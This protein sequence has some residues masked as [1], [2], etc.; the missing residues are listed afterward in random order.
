MCSKVTQDVGMVMC[1][2]SSWRLVGMKGTTAVG[3]TWNT[4]VGKT[5]NLIS[6]LV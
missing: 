5:P 2:G 1:S 6:Y 4:L 3:V